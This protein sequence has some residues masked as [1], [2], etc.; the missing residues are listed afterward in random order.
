VCF[1]VKAECYHYLFDAALKLH[2]LGLDPADPKHGPLT[3]PQALPQASTSKGAAASKVTYT[4][5]WSHSYQVFVHGSG[6]YK[7]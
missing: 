4:A 3:R 7:N 1:C 2:Q 5:F 6:K